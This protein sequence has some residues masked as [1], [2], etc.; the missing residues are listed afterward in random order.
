MLWS[1]AMQLIQGMVVL[2]P[3]HGSRKRGL[4]LA[5]IFVAHIRLA[6]DGDPW[7]WLT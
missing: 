3:I 5:A 2:F 7:I 1:E 4:R 6:T